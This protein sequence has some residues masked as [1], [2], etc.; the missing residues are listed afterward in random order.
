MNTE[1]YYIEIKDIHTHSKI[2]KAFNLV[3]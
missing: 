1:D 3:Y 2:S